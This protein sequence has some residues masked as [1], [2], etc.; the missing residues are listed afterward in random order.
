[1]VGFEG[2]GVRFNNVLESV[3][4]THL[5]KPCASIVSGFHQFR[6]RG[7]YRQC[8]LPYK[9]DTNVTRGKYGVLRFGDR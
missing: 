1:M 3:R 4:V 2:T 6:E 5:L 8:A 9:R 7:G